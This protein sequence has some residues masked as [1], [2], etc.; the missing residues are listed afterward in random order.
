MNVLRFS[1]ICGN[2]GHYVMYHSNWDIGVNVDF[3]NRIQWKDKC[4][5]KWQSTD[6]TCIEW[7]PK[8]NLDQIEFLAA[9]RNLV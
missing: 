3:V 5:C 4:E 1:N 6:C 9:K 7:V 8:D 2:C